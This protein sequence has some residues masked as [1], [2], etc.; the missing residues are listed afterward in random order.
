MV[1]KKIQVVE[2]PRDAM[3]GIKTLIPTQD[4]VNYIN[5]LIKVGF[6]IIDFGSFVSPKAVPQMMDTSKVINKLKIND[7]TSLLAIVLN[8]RGAIDASC[9]E[10]IKIVGYP[11]SISEFFQKNNSNLDIQSS[12]LII[13]DI[14]DICLQNNKI[15]LVYF[16]MAFGNPY[17][18]EWNIN[19]LLEYIHKI[20][21][22]G[23]KMISLA[24][25]NGNAS[26]KLIGDVYSKVCT[27]FHDLDIGLHLHT[28]PDSASAKINSA[29]NAGCQRFDVAIGGYGGC[30]F[31]KNKLIGNLST[32]Q[33]FN[34]IAVNNISHSLNSLA[35]ENAYNY[36]KKI[37]NL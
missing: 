11:L 32:E 24:D 29:W 8:K 23:I 4:K 27:S 28:H 7:E 12:L 14:L 13:D 25:T 9:F 16:S 36:S 10:Q 30:P 15:L 18:E 31:K 35:F 2:C 34:F 33:M 6:D 21:Q 17:N 22:K 20:H 5:S 1:N 19:L 3:Q 26:D 37:F